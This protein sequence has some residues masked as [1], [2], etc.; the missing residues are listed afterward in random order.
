MRKQNTAHIKITISEQGMCEL[1]F[2]AYVKLNSYVKLQT[3]PIHT[4]IMP[5]GREVDSLQHYNHQAGVLAFFCL[6]LNCPT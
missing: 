2:F 5:E 4:L 3:W 6:F 1:I